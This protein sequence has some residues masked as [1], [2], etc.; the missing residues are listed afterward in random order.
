[1]PSFFGSIFYVKEIPKT[2]VRGG[3]PLSDVVFDVGSF[4]IKADITLK[5]YYSELTML[6]ETGKRE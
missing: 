4:K 5:L 3:V 2:R 6:I 1:M